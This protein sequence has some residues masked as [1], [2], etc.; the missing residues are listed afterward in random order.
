MIIEL[1]YE[2]DYF[3]AVNKPNNILVHHSFMSRNKSQE[4]SLLNLFKEQGH[5]SVFPVHR[6]DRKTS[7]ILIL[8]KKKEA[9]DQF[10]NIF[11]NYLV[12]KVYHA[13]VR[14]F[15]PPNGCIVS[16]VK[17]RDSKSHK[18]A[19]TRFNHL[20][21]FE[22]N[23]PVHSYETSRYSLI[24]LLPES[25]R[26]HQ[27]RIHMT[28]MSHPIVGDS[29]Y[30]DRFHNRM[31]EREWACDFMFLDALSISFFHPFI[32]KEIFIIAPYPNHWKSV[33]EQLSLRDISFS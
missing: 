20:G 8:A 27:L 17:G 6:L 12:Q 14:G 22:L 9:V 19:L 33:F 31:I 23:I 4:K 16:T 24:E 25:D 2:D 11:K 1:C 15:Y 26:M 3:I 32:K 21:Q 10:Q 30:G 7:V 29:K 18:E 28:K 13:L 5:G